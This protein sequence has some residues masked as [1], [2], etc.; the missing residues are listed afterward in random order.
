MQC[1]GQ[2]FKQCRQDK[3]IKI[4]RTIIP[5]N[6]VLK[7]F[8]PI[9]AKLKQ[10]Y[11]LPAAGNIFLSQFD[12]A[13]TIKIFYQIILIF[14]YHICAM[15]LF[16]RL[17]ALFPFCVL[18]HSAIAHGPEGH[19]TAEHHDFSSRSWEVSLETGWESRHVHFGVNETGN[20]SAWITEMSAGIKEWIFSVW[21]GF[22]IDNNYQEWNFTVARNFDL[23]TVFLMPGYN[24]WYIPGLVEDGHDAEEEHDEH[25]HTTSANE[26]FFVLGTR[27]IPYV[28]PNAVFVW[29]LNSAPGAFTELRLDGNVPFWKDSLFVKPYALLGI[30]F[31]YNTQDYY[32]W[33][34]VQTG[35]EVS[36]KINNAIR[37]FSGINYSV[38][39][40]ALEEIEQG[41]ETWVSVGI[42]FSY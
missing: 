17:L 3:R 9:D 34:N 32:G 23:G 26:I 14:C 11:I 5:K 24:F 35:V 2:V 30:N 27:R 7:A 1:L 8:F 22:G 25:V 37:I 29:N 38:A 21:S 42:S 39:L 41:D 10:F 16:C 18:V 28:T 19:E 20:G 4:V 40:R 12:S 36:W 13:T 6:S 33:N 15:K 31:G